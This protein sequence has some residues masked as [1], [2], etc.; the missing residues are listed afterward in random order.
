V[1]RAA[2]GLGV[3]LLVLVL[4]VAA[5]IRVG[6]WDVITS[7]QKAAW[8]VFIWSIPLFGSLLA[9]QITSEPI[10][11]PP[12]GQSSGIGIGD[13]AGLDVGSH[14]GGGLDGGGHGGDGGGGH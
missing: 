7:A 3:L 9:L 2:V 8:F 13:T 5:S 6:R 4:D 12:T 10:R 1:V 14:G 11:G